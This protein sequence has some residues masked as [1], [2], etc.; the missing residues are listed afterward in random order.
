MRRTKQTKPSEVTLGES[1]P[2]LDVDG[3]PFRDLN[4]NGRLDIY[5]DRRAPIEDRVED[6]LS[7]MTV[8]EKVGLMFHTPVMV[9]GKDGIDSRVTWGS[10]NLTEMVTARRINHFNL[11]MAPEPTATAA[12]HNRVQ[13]LAEQTRLGIPVTFSSDPR[14]AAGFNPGAG[15]KQKGFSEWPSQL[16]LAATNDE[17]TVEGFGD[18]GRQ[19]FRAM[20]IRT[21]LNPMADVASEPRWGRVGGT[22]GDNFEQVG[23]LTAAYVRGFQAGDQGVAP[24]SVSC[25]VKHFPGCGPQE[26]GTEPHFSFGANQLYP[27]GRFRDHLDPFRAAIGAGARQV[28]LSYGIPVGQTSEDVAPAYN[29]EIVT[30]LL[31]NELGFDGVVCTD[32]MTH[33]TEKVFGF[34]TV[35][36][37]SAWGVEHLSI[38]ERYTTSLDAGVDQFGGQ[39]DPETMVGLV[40]S[41]EIAEER[42]DESARRILRL[43]FEMGLF[44]DPYVDADAADAATSTSAFTSAGIEAQR[45]SMVLLT[46]KD[47]A[48]VATLPATGRRRLYV[49]GVDRKTAARYGDVVSSPKKADLAIISTAAPTERKIRKEILS[50]FFAEGD[51][52]FSKRKLKRILGICESVPT[53]VS[54]RIDR[55][56]VIPEISDE[57]AAVFA[58]FGVRDE[59]LLDAVFGRFSPSGKLPVEMPASMR[60]VVRSDE[61]V[62]GTED[63]LFAHGHGLSYKATESR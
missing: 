41:G 31:R 1:A 62:P 2:L 38:P 42:I 44:D 37:A 7:Q 58:S 45:R 14:H 11:L 19:E 21:V 30:D 60:G 8:E 13:K 6:I 15:M 39:S 16:G 48:G 49:R 24:D 27:G 3:E 50:L 56:A 57:A 54:V 25:M 51:L 35:K 47:S 33:E 34:I 5:E 17:D 20:G 22:F 18:I 63:P 52:R 12:W 46:N 32:W 26:E 59:V 61:D 4:G 40:A 23:R 36:E 43:K 28:M 53:V 29:K 9:N 55:P 10:A